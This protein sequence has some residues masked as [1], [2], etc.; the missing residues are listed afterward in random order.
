MKFVSLNNKLP[1]HTCRYPESRAVQRKIVYHAGP[2][3]SGKTH[4]ALERF[5]N[6]KSG[7]YCGPLRLLAFQV[8]QKLNDLVSIFTGCLSTDVWTPYTVIHTCS[9]AHILCKKLIQFMCWKLLNLDL[10]RI[11]AFS[12]ETFSLFYGTFRL[13]LLKFLFKRVSLCQMTTWRLF[14][15]HYPGQPC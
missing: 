12:N 4:H 13:V 11:V 8:F 6:A 10:H 1:H 3:N 5:M 15:G 9:A 2:T 7:V 14:N